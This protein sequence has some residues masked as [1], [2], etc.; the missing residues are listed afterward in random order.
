[1]DA[2]SRERKKTPVLDRK[3]C[4]GSRRDNNFGDRD[5]V[6]EDQIILDFEEF[7]GDISADDATGVS[8]PLGIF[9]D[10]FRNSFVE[11]VEFLSEK[12]FHVS[13][14][15]V[16]RKPRE[17][18][19]VLHCVHHIRG[20]LVLEVLANEGQVNDNINTSLLQNTLVVVSFLSISISDEC[21][22]YAEFPTPDFS[23]S[24]GDMR[25]PAERITSR[26]ARI[27]DVPLQVVK[28]TPLALGVLSLVFGCQISF[29]ALEFK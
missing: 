12:V 13:I 29:S 18:C 27:V 17:V 20:G 9:A 28:T 26:L 14:R 4:S 21:Y 5:L 15:C 25:L 7:L 3:V 10:G 22:T 19:C 1:M 2:T 11:R 6:L 16:A 24:S 8:C 23:N